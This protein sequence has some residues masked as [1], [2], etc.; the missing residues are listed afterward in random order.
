MPKNIVNENE[1]KAT[2][3]DDDNNVKPC[4]NRFSVNYSIKK[5]CTTLKIR[6]R[7]LFSCL[8]KQA[9]DI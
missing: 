1:E 7:S 8:N 9:M 2:S 5:K 4:V 3:D 6:Y